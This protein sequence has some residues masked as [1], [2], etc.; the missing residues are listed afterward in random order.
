MARS[1]KPRKAYTAAEREG[2]AAKAAGKRQ[3]CDEFISGALDTL[4]DPATWQQVIER[5]SSN[6]GRYSLRNQLLV[7]AQCPGATDVRGYS[8]WVAGGR[9]VRKGETGIMIFGPVTKKVVKDG[10]TGKERAAEKGE[11]GATVKMAGLKILSVFDRAQTDAIEG[12]EEKPLA[13]WK[14]KSLDEIREA[15]AEVAG[16][17]AE[18]I[19]AAMQ[20]AI[21]GPEED[22]EAD[23]DEDLEED[24]EAA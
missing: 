7:G 20:E 12:K 15:I 9:Q 22:E 24:E 3:A 2:F 19:L 14:A 5:A 8:D 6:V 11:D 4:T 10:E 16:D 1:A 17:H 13:G 23:E 18:D 21:D